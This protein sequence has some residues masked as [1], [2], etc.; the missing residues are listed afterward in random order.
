MK[1][2]S[3]GGHLSS[4]QVWQCPASR[5]VGAYGRGVERVWQYDL[6]GTA[7]AA[8]RWEAIP[9]DGPVE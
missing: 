3:V 7:L 9:D 6:A 2:I 1:I 5:A 4:P 8:D